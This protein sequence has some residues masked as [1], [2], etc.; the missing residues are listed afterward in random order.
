MV[1]A[2][3]VTVASPVPAAEL[4]PNTPVVTAFLHNSLMNEAQV[5]LN[6]VVAAYN[7]AKARWGVAAVLA[8]VVGMVVGHV[9]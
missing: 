9:L 1:D 5:L 6:D 4:H 7:A 8:F 2:P 3:K